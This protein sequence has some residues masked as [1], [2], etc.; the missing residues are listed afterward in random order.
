MYIV[1][2]QRCPSLSFDD[3]LRLIATQRIV[4][5][6]WL[7]WPYFTVSKRAYSMVRA[8]FRLVLA[9]LNFVTIRSV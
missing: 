1:G 7:G 5:C 8:S 6:G 2:L 3:A 9:L 4:F